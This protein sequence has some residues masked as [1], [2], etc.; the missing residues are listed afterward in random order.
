MIIMGIQEIRLSKQLAKF[1][2]ALHQKLQLPKNRHLQVNQSH[3]FQLLR[4]RIGLRKSIKFQEALVVYMKTHHPVTQ[5]RFFIL[6]VTKYANIDSTTVIERTI[7]AFEVCFHDIYETYWTALQ[8]SWFLL[9]K[10]SQQLQK[11][12]NKLEYYPFS[13]NISAKKICLF[14]NGSIH[15][16]F[17]IYFTCG[18]YIPSDFFLTSIF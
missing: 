18:V 8:F 7:I 17:P 10:Q 6:L 4:N 2:Q 1:L 5:V 16:K 11:F 9:I 15:E 12:P 3:K 14:S 13:R